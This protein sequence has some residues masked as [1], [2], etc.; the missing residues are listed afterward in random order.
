MGWKL[1]LTKKRLYFIF[2]MEFLIGRQLES[3]LLNLDVEHEI[4][5]GL[6]ELGINLDEIIETEPDPGLGNGGLGR[7]A[8]CFFRLNGISWN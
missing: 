5:Q 1:E 6:K 7:L 3:N 8:A 2:S 4:E